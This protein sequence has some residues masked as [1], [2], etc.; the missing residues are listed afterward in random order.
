MI[1]SA[2]SS[3]RLSLPEPVGVN[4][5]PTV[6]GGLRSRVSEL[7]A[8]HV[9]DPGNVRSKYILAGGAMTMLAQNDAGERPCESW[10]ISNVLPPFRFGLRG[11]ITQQMPTSVRLC[12]K[13]W[14]AAS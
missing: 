6:I 7:G 14:E 9:V 10:M 4:R 8:K 2:F 11:Q 5:L 3:H 13:V 1:N 12:N